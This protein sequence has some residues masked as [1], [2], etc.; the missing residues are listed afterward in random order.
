MT[1]ESSENL[2]EETRKLLSET[3]A[4]TAGVIVAILFIGVISGAAAVAVAAGLTGQV[5]AWWEFVGA[6]AVVLFVPLLWAIKT[7]DEK[8]RRANVLR[9]IIDDRRDQKEAAQKEEDQRW[10]AKEI[11]KGLSFR[12]QAEHHADGNLSVVVDGYSPAPR[13]FDC[14]ISVPVTVRA[15]RHMEQD[16]A[17]GHLDARLS[18]LAGKHHASITKIVVAADRV[19][20]AKELAGAPAARVAF[21]SHGDTVLT[22]EAKDSTATGPFTP[23]CAWVE[24]PDTSP[25][26]TQARNAT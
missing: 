5:P 13:S 23:S 14:V 16:V 10:S 3:V 18:F 22:V 12:F 20:V 11:I 15:P 9:M 25:G 8:I 7:R 26:A 24:L 1:A 2:S 17:F 4:E 6:F 21:V 19:A